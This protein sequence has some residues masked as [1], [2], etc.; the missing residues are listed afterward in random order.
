MLRIRG[1][2]EENEINEVKRIAIYFNNALPFMK[3]DDNL[4][5]SSL[6]SEIYCGSTQLYAKCLY[7]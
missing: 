1:Y 6:G 2:L 3:Q 4:Q 7:Y 5:T